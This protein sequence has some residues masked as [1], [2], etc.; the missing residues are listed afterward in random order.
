MGNTTLA[1]AVS[2]SISLFILVLSKSCYR[3][4]LCCFGRTRKRIT[5]RRTGMFF[6]I[7][8]DVHG[9]NRPDVIDVIRCGNPSMPF[10][11]AARIED[12]PG[13][14]FSL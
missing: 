4:Q 11:V 9:S 5:R 14:G 7:G 6:D 1:K 12:S 13:I 2:V 10:H 3:W 8:R